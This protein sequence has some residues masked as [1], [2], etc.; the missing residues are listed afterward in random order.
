VATLQEKVGFVL[1]ENR[2]IRRISKEKLD[3]ILQEKDLVIESHGHTVGTNFTQTIYKPVEY[4]QIQKIE[5]SGVEPR[6]KTEV[7]YYYRFLAFSEHEIMEYLEK[8][9]NDRLV[10]F[11]DSIDFRKEE[12]EEQ[13]RKAFN[14]LRQQHLIKVVKDIFGKIRFIISDDTVRDLI[15]KNW[16]I[17]EYRLTILHHKMNYL[18]ELNN[19]ERQ[20]LEQKFGKEEADRMISSANLKRQSVSREDKK[21]ASNEME[22]NIEYEERLKKQVSEKYGRVIEEYGFVTDLA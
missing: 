17:H 2:H 18:E 14:N 6:E 19:T 5:V 16:T 10:P 21:V 7:Y 22:D 12:L 15:G 1:Q 20:W 13:F 3:E 9:N 8:S 11:V 4:T